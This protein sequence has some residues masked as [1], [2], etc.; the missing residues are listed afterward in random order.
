MDIEMT[1]PVGPM[2]AV[3]YDQGHELGIPVRITVCMDD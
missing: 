3:G 1:S 2:I